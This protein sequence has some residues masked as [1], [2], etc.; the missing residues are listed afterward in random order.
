MI[1]T[2]PGRTPILPQ[3]TWVLPRITFYARFSN[4]GVSLHSVLCKSMLAS[5]QRVLDKNAGAPQPTTRTSGPHINMAIDLSI[6]RDSVF[7]FSW[8]TPRSG[9]PT[10]ALYSDANIPN[11]FP[12]SPRRGLHSPLRQKPEDTFKPFPAE[13]YPYIWGYS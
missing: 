11:S 1:R 8:D 2:H 7:G 12:S 9:Y 6:Y 10:I 3:I 13:G 4:N 5:R